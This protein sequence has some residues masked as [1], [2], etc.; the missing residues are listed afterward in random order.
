MLGLERVGVQDNF[1]ELGGHSLLATWQV[2]ARI[3]ERLHIDLQ[4]ITL[5]PT[6]DRG[7]ARGGSGGGGTILDR[8]ERLEEEEVQALL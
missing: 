6:A 8:I 5:L 7:A 4:L 2:V 3:R 1:F